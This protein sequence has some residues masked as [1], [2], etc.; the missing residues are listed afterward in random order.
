MDNKFNNPFWDDMVFHRKPIRNK[1]GGEGG[2]GNLNSVAMPVTEALAAWRAADAGLA[3]AP[4]ASQDVVMGLAN[5]ANAINLQQG[6]DFSPSP[7][8]SSFPDHQRDSYEE[9]TPAQYQQ[10]PNNS[11]TSHKI[12]NY[13]ELVLQAN[14]MNAY[15][16][17]GQINGKVVTFL[18]DTG[19]TQVSIP[20][21]VADALGLKPSGRASKA[22]TANGL[23]TIYETML[24]QL[25]IGDIEFNHVAASINTGDHS[26]Q[27]LLGMS[28]LSQ[29]D[30]AQKE[31]KLFLRQVTR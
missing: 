22:R 10:N 23:V 21:R 12:G 26:E 8:G 14:Y 19:A 31:G 18:V 29:L 30:I 24:E 17:R 13:K 25:K 7:F 28:L 2:A 20:Q 5:V 6:N 4:A 11:P 27:I 1:K 3:Y 16:T 15:L 9:L